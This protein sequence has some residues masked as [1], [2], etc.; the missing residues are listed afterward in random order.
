MFSDILS[1]LFVLSC[2]F[3]FIYCVIKVPE[4]VQQS[5]K[6]D[7]VTTNTAFPFLLTFW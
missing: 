4:Q 6:T 2:H 3:Q 1:N 7:Q 5:R